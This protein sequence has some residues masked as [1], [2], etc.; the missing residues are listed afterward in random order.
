M[1]QDTPKT[2]LHMARLLPWLTLHEEIKWAIARGYDWHAER[3]RALD[4]EEWE[5]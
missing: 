5:G 2:A 3:L 4:D 1:E